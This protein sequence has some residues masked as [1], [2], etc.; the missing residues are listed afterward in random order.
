MTEN[1]WLM[2]GCLILGWMSGLSLGWFV[3]R[4]PKLKYQGVE[5]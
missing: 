4:R 1:E 2:V 5:E 3:W